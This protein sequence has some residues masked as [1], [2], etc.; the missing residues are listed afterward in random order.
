MWNKFKTRIRNKKVIA[1]IVSG[2]LI[3]LVNT[4]IIG[5][6]LSAKVTDVLNTLLSVGVTI[7]IL[8]DPTDHIK[9]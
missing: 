6:D 9:E 5:E 1:A 3:I 7:G 8:G 4:G 2:V